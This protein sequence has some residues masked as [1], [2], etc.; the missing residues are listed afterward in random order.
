MQGREFGLKR[1]PYPATPD[2]AYYY[3]ASTHERAL[4]RLLQAIQD[5]DGFAVLTGDPGTGKTLL[6]H[7]LVDRLG[8]H[9]GEV[10]CVFLVNGHFGDR[11]GLLQ[12][13]LFDLGL[14]YENAGEQVLRLRLTERLLQNRAAGKRTILLVDEAQHLSVDLLEEL[15]LLGNLEAGHGKTLQVVLVGQPKLL[16]T[17]KRA[18]LKALCQRLVVRAQLDALGVEEGIDYLLH[19]VRVAGGKPDDLWEEPAL[20]ILARGAAG[21]PRLLNQVAHHALALAQQAEMTRVD[22]EAALEALAN[23]GLAGDDIDAESAESVTADAR[24]AIDLD[25]AD[26]EPAGVVPGE[27]LGCRLFDSPRS[28]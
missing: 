16:E 12:A 11:L 22:A 10:D 8:N 6:C 15:R 20:E 21:V 3:P 13:I 14:P 5:D 26:N 1:R 27:S 17:L 18:E 4:D 19:H 25:L 23:L 2:R 24:P 7:C 9:G 28:A